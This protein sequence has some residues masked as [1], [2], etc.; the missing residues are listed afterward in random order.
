MGGTSAG[1]H[2]GDFRIGRSYQLRHDQVQLLFSRAFPKEP[3][4]ERGNVLHI[5]DLISFTIIAPHQ[6]DS[7]SARN[8]LQH[9]K[10]NPQLGIHS[11]EGM[12]KIIII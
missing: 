6:F 3:E 11:S 7:L 10:D 9:K 1:S 8:E 5:Q 2:Y 4:A 12:N